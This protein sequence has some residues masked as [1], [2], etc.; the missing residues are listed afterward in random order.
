MRLKLSASAR[1]RDDWTSVDDDD[2][3]RPKVTFDRGRHTPDDHVYVGFY[4]DVYGRSK[5]FHTAFD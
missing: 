3:Q 1:I 5:T 4:Y 2:S